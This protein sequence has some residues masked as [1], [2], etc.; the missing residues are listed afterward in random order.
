VDVLGLPLKRRSHGGIV[1]HVGGSELLVS[2]V[3][4]TQPSAHT[5]AGFAVKN[6]DVVRSSLESRGLRWEHFPGF[7][8][9]ANG[10]VTTPEGAKV[11]W[12]RDPDG[13]IL[14]IVEYA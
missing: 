3:P 4:P 6:L 13:N 7:I 10:V 11:L 9:D 2:P 8:H 5:V 12:F 1:L 14:S